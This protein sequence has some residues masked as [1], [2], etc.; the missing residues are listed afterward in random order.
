[1]QVIKYTTDNF[2]VISLS[3]THSDNFILF[4]TCIC[5][6]EVTIFNC[7][8]VSVTF[9]SSRWIWRDEVVRSFFC[10]KVDILDCQCFSTSVTCI[11]MNID[12]TWVVEF[13]TIDSDIFAFFLWYCSIW[14]YVADKFDCCWLFTC[15][16]S[17]ES[18]LEEFVSFITY[19]SF[20]S[21]TAVNAFIAEVSV[22]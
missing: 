1:M 9:N 18:V 20:V 11:T 5:T 4:F 3:E 17:V 7:Y 21:M 8:I 16:N 15:F 22:V 10:C 14:S 12:S 2:D 19:L 13:L 6:C